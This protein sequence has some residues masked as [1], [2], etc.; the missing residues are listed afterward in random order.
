MQQYHKPMLG[1][2]CK[3]KACSEEVLNSLFNEIFMSAFVVSCRVCSP[4]ESTEIK[5]KMFLKKAEV[6]LFIFI[7]SF[8]KINALL[9]FK[10]CPKIKAHL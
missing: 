2:A 7:P 1:A 5:R 9:E 4:S 6:V 3:C 10:I 8:Q